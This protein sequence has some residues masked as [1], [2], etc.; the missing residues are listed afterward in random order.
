MK[1]LEFK[2]AVFGIMSLFFCSAQTYAMTINPD[3]QGTLVV[4]S[5]AGE[6]N[7]INAGEPVPDLV[8]NSIIEVLNGEFTIATAENE[9]V[10]LSC[11]GASVSV[12]GGSSASLS[13]G[14]DSG[15]LKAL[16]GSVTVLDAAGKKIVLAEGEEYSIGSGEKKKA[17]ATAAGEP[18]GGAPIGGGLAQNTPV[19]S[20]SLE[21]SP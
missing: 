2:I 19:D 17:P 1:K 13:C 18:T 21:S 15:L 20:R 8:S 9:S 11:H 12:D 10:Q 4:T 16:K 5:P 6:V 3:F 14:G 7:L